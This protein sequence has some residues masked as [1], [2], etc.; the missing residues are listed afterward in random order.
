MSMNKGIKTFGQ[1]G[2]DAVKKEMKQLHERKV[3]EAK[4]PTELS[5]KQR[6]EALGYL[7]FLKRKRCGTVKGRGC[8]DGRPQRKYISKEE[9]TSPTVSTEAV[10]LTAVI[11]AM[12]GREVAVVDVPGAFMQADMDEQVHVKLTG[13]MA[14]LLIE[15]DDKMYRP[16]L[17]YEKGKPVLYVELLKALYG[18]LRAARL[19]WEK[20]STK[21]QEWGYEFNPYDSCVMNKTIN[22]KQCTVV[23]HVDDIK[24][25]HEDT[26][27]IDQF[28]H[29]MET[30]FGKEAPLTKTREKILN[31]LGMKLDYTKKG[32]VTI[33]MREYVQMVVDQA[34]CDMKGNAKT[35]AASHLFEVNN[36]DPE[37]LNE[38]DCTTFH[39]ITMQLQYLSQRGRPDIRTAIAF[40]S[41][42]VNK[43]DRDDYKKLSRVISYLRNTVDLMLVLSADDSGEINWWVD[44]S[45]AV[46]PDMKGHTGGTMSLGGG[47][48][49]S[50]ST[51][52]KLVSRSSTES[53]LI[54]V[55]DTMPQ[56][57]WTKNFLESQGYNVKKSTLH[58]DNMS[59]ILLER[60]GRASSSKRTK[61]INIR[62]FFIKDHIENGDIELKYCPTEQMVADFFTK[63]IQG[64]LFKQLRDRIMNIDSSSIYHSN[65]RSVLEETVTNE[66]NSNATSTVKNDEDTSEDVGKKS[67]KDAVVNKE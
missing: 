55:Y 50:T 38:T 32:Q 61:H 22:D 19:F 18:T 57:I 43:P 7:M 41:S 17:T 15:I 5:P 39:H 27:V 4:K 65:H 30:E 1:A 44:A 12:Q 46:H 13:K 25:S 33:D 28:I 53:E 24:V 48:I 10:F 49:Y 3:M 63:P 47:S 21:L 6:R 59:S 29:D 16:C 14:E 45:H 23:W 51:K 37:L 35:P 67:Y 2:V 60:N 34:P 42:R 40:L 62:Y 54:G 20:L 58:Q 26:T 66:E 36:E 52:Q 8:A 11:D 31:Y 9:S 56:M 64:T